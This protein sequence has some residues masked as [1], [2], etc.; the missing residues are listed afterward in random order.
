MN[1]I[2]I[3]KENETYLVPGISLKHNTGVTRKVPHPQGQ[4][5]IVFETL[6]EAKAAIERAGF[7]Y[8]LPSGVKATVK[9]HF[10]QD[11]DKLIFDSLTALTSDTNNNVVAA[12]IEALGEIQNKESIDLFLEKIGED[13]EAIRSNATEALTKYGSAALEK[14]L[15]ALHDGNWVK[16]NSAI[17]CLERLADVSSVDL[18]TAVL[19]LIEKLHDTNNIVKSTA[20]RALGKIYKNLKVSIK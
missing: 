9:E 13:N 20:A 15:T 19:P 4:E 17:I 12:S 16:R 6:E 10:T 8:I 7:L 3:K 18:R 2:P 5:C 14:L 1:Y 11:Y